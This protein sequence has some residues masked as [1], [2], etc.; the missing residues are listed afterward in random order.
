MLFEF[1]YIWKTLVVFLLVWISYL[2]F[3]Y[4]FTVVT[5]L[6]SLFVVQCMLLQKNG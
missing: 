5:L 3:D 1:G 6:A 2:L 4:K